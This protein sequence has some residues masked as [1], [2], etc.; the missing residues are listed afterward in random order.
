MG[1]DYEGETGEEEAG[2][3]GDAEVGAAME[4]GRLCVRVDMLWDSRANDSYSWAMDEGGRNGQNDRITH[5]IHCTLCYGL[6]RP[7]K[8]NLQRHIGTGIPL[9]YSIVL[10]QSD[11]YCT[12]ENVPDFLWHSTH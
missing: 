10:E 8:R 1:A 9:I 6:V 11:A 4:T 5:Q 12:L 2:Y 7:P 3:V